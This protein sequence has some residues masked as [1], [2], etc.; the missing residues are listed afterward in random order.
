MT[1]TFWERSM[2]SRACGATSTHNGDSWR[3]SSRPKGLAGILPVSEKCSVAGLVYY[4]ELALAVIPTCCTLDV[5]GR[6]RDFPWHVYPSPGGRTNYFPSIYP[7]SG[8]CQYEGT[9]EEKAGWRQ[10]PAWVIGIWHVYWWRDATPGSCFHL[11]VKGTWSLCLIAYLFVLFCLPPSHWKLECPGSSSY[12]TYRWCACEPQQI[13]TYNAYILFYWRTVMMH[14]W[15]SVVRKVWSYYRSIGISY[16]LLKRLWEPGFQSFVHQV[17]KAWARFTC[18]TFSLIGQNLWAFLV[19]LLGCW[20]V[21]FFCCCCW[22]IIAIELSTDDYFSAVTWLPQ[23]LWRAQHCSKKNFNCFLTTFDFIPKDATLGHRTSPPDHSVHSA[24]FHLIWFRVLSFDLTAYGRTETSNSSDL[25]AHGRTE[26]SNSPDL[27]AY[28]QT[29]RGRATTWPWEKTR[30]ARGEDSLSVGTN[31]AR[32]SYL[33]PT[34]A[35]DGILLKVGM[36]CFIASLVLIH[37][38]HRP[39]VL[40]APIHVYM[41]RQSRTPGS[42]TLV[43]VTTKHISLQWAC[44]R[45]LS[46]VELPNATGQTGKQHLVISFIFVRVDYLT[47]VEWKEFLPGSSLSHLDCGSRNYDLSLISG[48]CIV[49]FTISIVL[50]P[51]AVSSTWTWVNQLLTLV[52]W[53]GWDRTTTY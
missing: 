28:G 2:M 10:C 33:L 9:K 40:V 53:L 39:H 30:R 36:G 34:L 21:L 37:S 6:T 45:H 44:N 26:T 38:Y 48:M 14:W 50:L 12:G 11:G 52:Q 47:T 1:F 41:W 24:N 46:M 20:F 19:F 7:H 35:Q 31:D 5:S 49:A 32:I 8:G 43:S 17:V 23:L 29:A 16:K 3:A 51:C 22:P 42:L 25:T 27:T 18:F 15:L 13:G 4:A